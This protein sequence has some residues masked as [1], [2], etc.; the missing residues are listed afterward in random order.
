MEAIPSQKIPSNFLLLDKNTPI[1]LNINGSKTTN[2]INNRSNGSNIFTNSSN[3]NKEIDVSI[4]VGF[5]FSKGGQI[6]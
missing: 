3:L 4:E 6:L 1:D 5:L 2:T